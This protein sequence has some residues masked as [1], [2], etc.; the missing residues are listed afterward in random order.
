MRLH[1]TSGWLGRHL[2]ATSAPNSVEVRAISAALDVPR[3]LQGGP[4]TIAVPNV[5][6]YGL[7]GDSFT[8]T[9]RSSLLSSAFD[10]A[11]VVIKNGV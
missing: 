10:D 5:A 2:L 1:E 6:E 8:K 3:C 4:K 9:L 7:G 11:H